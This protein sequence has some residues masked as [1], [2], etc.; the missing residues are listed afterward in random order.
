MRQLLEIELTD[1]EQKILDLALERAR[2][3]AKSFEGRKSAIILN[4][5]VELLEASKSK[6]SSIRKSSIARILVDT[7]ARDK[8][9]NKETGIS[10]DLVYRVLREPEFKGLKQNTGPK[11]PRPKGNEKSVTNFSTKIS[12]T[13]VRACAEVLAEEVK[14]L[15]TE[16]P[17]LSNKQIREE[18][19]KL[20]SVKGFS[21]GTLRRVWPGIVPLEYHNTGS[22]ESSAAIVPA[23]L[24]LE[25]I[26]KQ[27]QR[28]YLIG[29]LEVFKDLIQWL[30]GMDSS[31][32][33]AFEDHLQPGQS[34]LLTLGN[35]CRDHIKALV[36]MMPDDLTYIA[37]FIQSLDELTRLANIFDEELYTEKHLR[38]KK[39]DLASV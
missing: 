12:N 36:K 18:V 20:D 6:K 4:A 38:E 9:R 23:G 27:Q 2:Q 5:A 16:K 34:Y 3:N 39:R 37:G 30:S 13:P 17:G 28:Q 31:Q 19:E 32:R 29:R 7:F 24:S 8:E 25:A 14:K 10:R 33:S 1:K 26:D 11:G 22:Q 15:R 35:K 21:A